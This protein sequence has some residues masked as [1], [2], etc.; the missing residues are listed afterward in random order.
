MNALILAAGFGSR[1]MPLT[2]KYPKCMVE[3]RGKKIIDYEI[4]SLKEAKIEEIAVVGGYLFDV[5]ANHL[6]LQGITNLFCNQNY[7]NTNMVH[8]FFCAMDFLK[9]CIEEKKDL[10]I[11]Y[12]DILYPADFIK[13]L[14]NSAKED[15][16]IVVD[17]DWRNLWEKRFENPLSDAE[18]LKIRNDKLIELGKKPKGYEEIEGQYIGLLKFSHTFLSKVIEEYNLMDKEV[19]Y[20]GCSFEKMY[21][22]SFLQHLINR[23]GNATAVYIHGGWAEI[24]CVKD[25]EIIES[26]NFVF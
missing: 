5:L 19:D 23:F 12:S 20:D 25:L 7:A 18:T 21:M 4:E 3:Y 17:L 24:D 22:T 10:I 6:S 8:T 2:K 13:R 1:L 15:F 16:C 14:C 11:S 9:Q 26:E